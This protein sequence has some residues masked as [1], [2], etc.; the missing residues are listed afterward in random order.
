MKHLRS[1]IA[2]CISAFAVTSW[3]AGNALW[4]AEQ[5]CIKYPTPSARAEC[6]KKQKDDMA[7]FEKE[8]KKNKDDAKTS[9]DTP[10]DAK[11]KNDLCFKRESTGETVCPN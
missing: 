10:Q 3:A 1:L 2:L 11:K 4:Q 8:L 5:S 7:A 6:E 9:G